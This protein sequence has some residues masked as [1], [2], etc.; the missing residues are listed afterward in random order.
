ML[1]EINENNIKMDLLIKGAF[2]PHGKDINGKTLF[3]FKCKMHSKGAVDMDELKQCVIYWFE[4]MERLML[5]L[6]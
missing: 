2:F 4:R 5:S 6:H 1:A 3:V